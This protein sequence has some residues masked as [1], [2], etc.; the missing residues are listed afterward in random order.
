MTE[1]SERYWEARWRDEKAENERLREALRLAKD[2]LHIA[3]THIDRE[4][5]PAP[6]DRD[7]PTA[8][9]VRGIL[10]AESC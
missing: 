10:K 3:I 5:E 8:D 7:L 2:D 9:D 6:E 1:G 4:I